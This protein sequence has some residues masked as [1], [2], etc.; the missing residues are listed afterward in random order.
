MFLNY[1]G[2]D[3]FLGVIEAFSG[4]EVELLFVDG[5]GDFGGSVFAAYDASGE[6]VGFGEGVE[7]V[8]G[9]EVVFFSDSEDGDLFAFDEGADTGIAGNVV[10]VADFVEGEFSVHETSSGVVSWARSSSVA[11]RIWPRS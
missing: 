1:V 2:S 3:S 5:G 9:V 11:G 8:D 4:L 6:D 10:E 7:V